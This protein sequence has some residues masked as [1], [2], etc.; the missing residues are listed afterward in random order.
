MYL[1][2]KKKKKRQGIGKTNDVWPEN[3]RE[4]VDN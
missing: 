2:K 3:R 1:G 4:N